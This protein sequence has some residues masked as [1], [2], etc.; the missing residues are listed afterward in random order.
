[1]RVLHV[2]WGFSPWRPGGLI[3]YAEDLMAAQAERGHRVAYFCSGRHYPYL[4]GPRLKRRRRAGVTVYEVVNPPILAG[5][6]HGTRRPDLDLDEPRMEAAFRRVLG[7]ERPGVVHI[8]ELQSLPSS[9][10]DV[11]AEAGVPTLMTLQ[12]YFPLCATLRLY[13]ADGRRCMR[14]DVG[15]DCAARNAD[16]PADTGTL[17]WVTM[18]YELARARRAIGLGDVDFSPLGPLIAPLHRRYM[19]GVAQ[20]EQSD[21]GAPPA[22]PDPALAAAFR[23]R[24]DVN[25]E[26]LGRVGRLVAQSPRVAEIYR[27]LGV[28]AERMSTLPFTLAHVERLRPRTIGAPPD[29]ITF[30]TINGCASPSKGSETIRDTLRALRRAGA[31]G[32][33]RLVVLGQVHDAVAAELAGFERVELRGLYEPDQL[34]TLLDTVDVGLMPSMWEEALGYTG[35]EMIAKGIP[36]I[37]NPLGGIPEYARAGETAWLN[38]DLTG[39]GLARL[40]LHLV[41][42]PEQVV[43]MNRRVLAARAEVVKPMAHHVDAIEGMYRELAGSGA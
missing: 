33:F 1:M 5:L 22:G 28:P 40:M 15:A 21:P 4:S 13:D 14:R 26:R 32:R 37:A 12:D 2:G 39:E 17:T 27:T 29:P 25:V 38:E 10:I 9:L 42:R 3:A 8:Q 34:D 18:R 20:A 6:E 24:R 16:A 7:R 23:R 36:L 31:E 30:A 11:A 19:R 41:D 43:E 35:L